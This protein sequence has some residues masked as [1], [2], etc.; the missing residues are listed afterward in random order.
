QPDIQYEKGRGNY[1][2]NR[3]YLSSPFGQGFVTTK[4]DGVDVPTLLGNTN[5]MFGPRYDGT[6]M[7]E[8]YNGQM[9]TYEPVKDHFVKMYDPGWGTNTNVALRGSDEKGN[10]YLS[11][12]YT[13]RNGTTPSNEF[14]KTSLFFSGSRKLA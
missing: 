3:T 6:T 1:Y 11:T 5:R 13:K 7:I 14:E 4:K 12:G 9:V 8:D 2:G 10:F